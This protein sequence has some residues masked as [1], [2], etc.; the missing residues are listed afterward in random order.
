MNIYVWMNTCLNIYVSIHV[1]VSVYMNI[2]VGIYV[3]TP[4]WGK[5]EIAT[6]TFENGTWESFG[7]LEN[8]KR[9]CRGQNTL[10]LSV[11]YTIGKVLKFRCPKW[12]RMNHLDILNT[13][14]CWK[15]GQEPNWQFD[16]RPLKVGNWPDPG[17]FRWSVT[18]RW[19]ALKESYK[20]ASD[21]VPIG[22]RSKKLWTLKIP[23][24]QTG[25]VSGLHFRSL[26]KKCHSDASAMERHREYYMG[27]GGGFPRIQAIVS[28]VN[29]KLHVACPST[30][31]VPKCELT[32]LLV[33]LMQV[34][35]NE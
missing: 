33:S 20:F 35:V 29:P 18:H 2:Y 25:T 3:A 9:D 28:Q 24:V 11:F 26:G 7:I 5:C 15:K 6:H 1:W 14:Y 27:E 32:N 4:L 23:R 34:R 19:K 22:N 10:H 17:V 31:S 13:S 8:S 12:P 30:K 21:L 16:S